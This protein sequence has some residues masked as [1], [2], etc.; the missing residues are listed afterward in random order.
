LK[1][2]KLLQESPNIQSQVRYFKTNIFF[3]SVE[4]LAKAW[5]VGNVPTYLSKIFKKIS[6][7]SKFRD[8]NFFAA[9]WDQCY[10]FKNIFAEELV[11]F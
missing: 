2:D 7:M 4:D 1:S 10:Y 11:D 6:Q 8:S 9:N 5:Q 3:S